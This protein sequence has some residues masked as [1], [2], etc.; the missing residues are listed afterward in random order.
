MELLRLLHTKRNEFLSGTLLNEQTLHGKTNLSTITVSTPDGGARDHLPAR[1]RKNDYG[2]FAAKFERGRNEP[3]CDSFGDAAAS[4]HA[5]GEQDFVWRRVDQSLA[6][7]PAALDNFDEVSR[8][9]CVDKKFF[10]QH[11]ALRR[12]VACFAH[13]GVSRGDRRNDLAQRDG[14]RI[15]PRR[16]DSDDAERV[17]SKVTTLGLCSS[18]VMR[19]APRAESFHSIA[20]P[21]LRR[22][23][24]NKNIREECFHA[25]LA[26]FAHNS[27]RQP[28]TRSH[29]P[30]AK[31]AQPCASF[32]NRQLCPSALDN[33][34]AG[35]NL[36]QHR[37]GRSLKMR[38]HFPRIRVDRRKHVN[39]DGR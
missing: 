30:V 13:Y 15:V 2:I 36:R 28:V 31:H 10:N 35:N 20:G 27:L 1:T 14:Q 32:P 38:K 7:F 11:T 8:E 24:S 25:R 17:V 3:F 39:L 4:S 21:I 19:D 16:N 5:P 9:P 22:I 29:Y 23:E 26:G 37:R 6:N 18:A 33:A 12:E 34:R